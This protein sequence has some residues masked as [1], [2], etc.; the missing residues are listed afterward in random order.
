MTTRVHIQH[1]LLHDW[2]IPSDLQNAY[3]IEKPHNDWFAIAICLAKCISTEGQG[4][5]NFPLFQGSI[6]HFT[7]RSTY[8]LLLSATQICHTSIVVQHSIFVYSSTT[9]RD[10]ILCFHC[11]NRYAN[12][13]QCYVIRTL[14]ILCTSLMNNRKN[15]LC[16]DHIRQSVKICDQTVL[17][18]HE[19]QCWGSSREI[20][21]QSTR[22]QSKQNSVHEMFTKTYTALPTFCCTNL[23]TQNAVQHLSLSWKFVQARLF[24]RT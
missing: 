7:S 5:T 3:R 1:L 4:Q 15:T 6:G 9:H 19:I 21:W 20:S 24:L 10:C 22:L 14:P 11:N 17:D 2:F 12:A 23:G 13:P 18:F 16:G 8:V